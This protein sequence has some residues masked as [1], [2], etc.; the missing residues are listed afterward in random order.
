MTTAFSTQLGAN[1]GG[2]DVNFVFVCR[3]VADRHCPFRV[4]R[5]LGLG[6]SG[7]GRR[8]VSRVAAEGE[9]SLDS[10]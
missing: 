10:P 8:L 6:A 7:A 3:A 1:V 2:N 4:R 9:R 5:E